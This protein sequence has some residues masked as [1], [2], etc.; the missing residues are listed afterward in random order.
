MH[1]DS[2]FSKKK[3]FLKQNLYVK[4]KNNVS[5]RLRCKVG[6]NLAQTPPVCPPEAFKLSGYLL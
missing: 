1:Q 3:T 4:E 5:S 6:G 2:D